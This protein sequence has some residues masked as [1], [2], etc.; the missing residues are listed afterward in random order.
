MKGKR[1]GGEEIWKGVCEGG[2]IKLSYKAIQNE[3]KK[4]IKVCQF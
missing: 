1:G 4:T 3:L 2:L